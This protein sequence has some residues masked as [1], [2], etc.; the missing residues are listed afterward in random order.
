[1]ERAQFAAL[2]VMLL[3]EKNHAAQTLRSVLTLAGITRITSI[4]SSC[5]ALELLTMDNFDAIFCDEQ[6]DS[7]DGLTFPLAVRRISGILNPLIPIFVFQERAR[8]R[9]VEAARDTGAT[10]FLTC[11][12]SPKTVMTKL[13]A[14]LVNPRPFI[15]APEYFGPDRRARQRPAWSGEDRRT[16]TPRKIRVTKGGLMPSDSDPVL[17]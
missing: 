3:S 14:A 1:M 16:R 13:E 9:S 7:V 2:G 17:I 11:P 8:R 10:D 5:R 6:C 4:V 15:K 12:I